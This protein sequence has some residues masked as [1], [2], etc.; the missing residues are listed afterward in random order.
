MKF[1]IG[2]KIIRN[3][4][5]PQLVYKELEN[6]TIYT[7]SGIREVSEYTYVYELKERRGIHTAIIYSQDNVDRYF[8][9]VD[10]QYHR[11]LKIKKLKKSIDERPQ[12]M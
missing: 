6:G 10:N 9:F 11:S 2:D 12:G 1:K 3:N 8:D 7:I 5:C 4:N